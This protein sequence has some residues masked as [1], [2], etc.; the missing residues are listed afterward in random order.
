MGV[1]ILLVSLKMQ[2]QYAETSKHQQG[3]HRDNDQPPKNS[4]HEDGYKMSKVWLH[5]FS[6]TPSQMAP[7]YWTAPHSS[8]KNF[9]E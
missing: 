9:G 3:N 1:T 6:S 2:G 4:K 7:S 8:G 5:I